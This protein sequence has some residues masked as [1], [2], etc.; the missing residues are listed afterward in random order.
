M[1][2]SLHFTVKV[3]K[4]R[5]LMNIISFFRSAGEAAVAADRRHTRLLPDPVPEPPGG[6][7]RAGGGDSE[8]REGPTGAGGALG[9]L[10]LEHDPVS[11][12]KPDFSVMEEV[13][14]LMSISYRIIFKQYC[15]VCTVLLHKT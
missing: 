4:S 13:D 2:K 15:S 12:P 10:P 14:F 11:Q 5:L 1:E 6:E 8:A 3:F 7:A 9:E